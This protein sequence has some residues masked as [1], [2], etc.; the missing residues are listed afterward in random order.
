[1]LADSNDFL[2]DKETV[3]KVFQ[4]LEYGLLGE[5]V[6]EKA[7]KQKVDPTA[8]PQKRKDKKVYIF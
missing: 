6:S 8:A 4:A 3:I 7:A 2:S 5:L 1:M